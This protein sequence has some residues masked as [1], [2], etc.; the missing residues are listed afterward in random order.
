MKDTSP[1]RV[2]SIGGGNGLSALLQGLKQFTQ[3]AEPALPAWTLRPL[4]R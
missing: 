4:S 3:S 2:V 1:L